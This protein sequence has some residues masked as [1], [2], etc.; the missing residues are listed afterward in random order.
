VVILTATVGLT[1][2]VERSNGAAS[3]TRQTIDRIAQGFQQSV[4]T[5]AFGILTTGE[6]D[7]D[8]SMIVFTVAL[9]DSKG[10]L[11]AASENRAY[12]PVRTASNKHRLAQF[13]ITN[14][15]YA[16]GLLS[17]SC[18]TVGI[19]ALFSGS[20]QVTG[21]DY[22]TDGTTDVLRF[23]AATSQYGAVAPNPN[24]AAIRLLLTTRYDATVSSTTAETRA[25]SGPNALPLTVRTT[26]FRNYPYNRMPFSGQFD[27]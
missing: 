17:T 18:T 26:A 14:G 22:L 23:E 27:L 11:T 15:T 10:Q 12:C 8:Q 1:Q 13:I 2:Q 7:S 3:Q 16:G 4:S 24:P 5:D 21:P 25:D 9:A 20:P 6:G 19:A